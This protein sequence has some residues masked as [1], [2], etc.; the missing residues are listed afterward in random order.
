[1]SVCLSVDVRSYLCAYID[2]RLCVYMYVKHCVCLSVCLLLVCLAVG[3]NAAL[4]LSQSVYIWLSACLRAF[5]WLY[6]SVCQSVYLSVVGRSVVGLP[7]LS[8]RHGPHEACRLRAGNGGRMLQARER[9]ATHTRATGY[10][11]KGDRLG[12]WMLS[13]ERRLRVGDWEREAE[14]GGGCIII[15]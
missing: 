3:L 4:S 14:R 5:V 12:W 1:M 13:Q 7:Q 6:L 8:V 11:H 10:A 9:K 15:I 2:M